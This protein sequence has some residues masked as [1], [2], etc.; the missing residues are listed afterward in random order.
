M[1]TKW[2]LWKITVSQ[3]KIREKKC[4]LLC[5][6]QISFMSGLIKG[7][8]I[9]ISASTCNLLPYCTSWTFWKTQL[10]TKERREWKAP[11]CPAQVAFPT[12][13]LILKFQVLFVSLIGF[14]TFVMISFTDFFFF[15]F[16]PLVFLNWRG[17]ISVCLVHHYFTGGCIQ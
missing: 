13:N 9:L 14:Q 1:L 6:L 3:S 17:C 2:I 11:H 5:I 4:I 8:W 7:R 15:I 10:C 16:G 12:S